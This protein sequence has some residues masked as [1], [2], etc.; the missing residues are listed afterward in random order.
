VASEAADEK[1]PGD[2]LSAV[3]LAADARREM[4]SAT[5]YADKLPVEIARGTAGDCCVKCGRVGVDLPDEH[6]CRPDVTE[7][8]LARG[9][10]YGC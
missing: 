2:G 7:Q 4:I 8:E 5:T 10:R 1:T 9:G 6:G 3:I